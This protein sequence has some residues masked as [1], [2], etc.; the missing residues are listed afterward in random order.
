MQFV[1][2]KG[3][4]RSEIG[5]KASSSLRKEGRVPCVMYAGGE[6][7]LH[8]AAESKEVSNLIYT[9][10]F[11]KAKVVIDG[12]EY[13]CILKQAQF[14]PVTD[15]LIHVDF[16]RLMPGTPITVRVPVRL[17]GFSKGVQ[18]GGRLDLKIRRLLI[19]ALPKDLV[20]HIE[21]D[22][23]DLELGKS[24]KVKDL[25]LENIEIMN[26]PTSPV[27][28]VTIP[29]ALRGGGDEEEEGT[30]EDGEEGSAEGG[31]SGEGSEAPAE[32]AAE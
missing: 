27:T 15:E 11:Q 25:N 5:K 28:Q 8:F 24:I 22:V 6:D 14:H 4:V 1:N 31:E 18:A 29:R 32:Q 7:T 10:E 17:T 16:Q 13:E 30:G 20:D 19:K 12:Q 9:D 21:L 2:I 23:T 26:S 3:S